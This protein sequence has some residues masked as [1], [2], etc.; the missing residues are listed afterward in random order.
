M[1]LLFIT[2]TYPPSIG[3][4]Q[5]FSRDFYTHYRTVG[6]IDLIANPGG[7]KALPG[8]FFKAALELALES[9]KYDVIHF[10]DATL[11]LLLPIVR[12]CSKAK[13][14]ATVHGLDIVY[15]RFGYQRVIPLFLRRFDRLFPV[16]QYTLEQ[17]EARGVSSSRLKVIPD[18]IAG[19]RDSGCEDQA[20]DAVIRK[21]CIP[22]GRKILL[23]VGRLV[24]RKGQAWFISEVLRKLPDEY[25]YL[26]AGTGPEQESIIRLVR[27]LHLSGRVCLL[28]NVSEQEKD[29]LYRMADLF[30]MPNMHVQG[31]Q[32]GFGI[33]VLE[34]GIHGLPVIASK[35]EGI[36]DTLI[37]GKTGRLVEEKDAQAFAEAIQS[38]GIDRSAVADLVASRFAWGQL[39]KI[40]KEEFEAML[41]ASA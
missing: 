9:R 36:P 26:V 32:E 33:V 41:G 27:D 38:P 23:T 12:L 34:A 18:G 7:R 13:A 11:A 10:G 30:I 5:A 6:D 28:G 16:S 4:M 31:D 40:Y 14:S 3:G 29:C 21:F 35:I 25:L 24:K 39:A 19:D 22:Q 20:Q 1:K 2:R 17:C 37:E 15:S 8:F